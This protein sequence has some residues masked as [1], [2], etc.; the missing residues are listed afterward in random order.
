MGSTEGN[1]VGARRRPGNE[2]RWQEKIPQDHSFLSGVGAG[3]SQRAGAAGE[4]TGS[5]CAEGEVD[6]FVE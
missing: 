4:I 6:S 5:R 1:L 3:D 2:A